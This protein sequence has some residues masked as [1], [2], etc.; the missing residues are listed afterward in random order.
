MQNFLCVKDIS[1]TGGN[2]IIVTSEKKRRGEGGRRVKENRQN[3]E[4]CWNWGLSVGV[5]YVTDSLLWIF[6]NSHVKEGKVSERDFK[7]QK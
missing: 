3:T 1:H 2:K 7:P 6:E 4:H 5:S